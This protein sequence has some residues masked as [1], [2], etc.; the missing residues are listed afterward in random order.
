MSD[1]WEATHPKHPTGPAAPSDPQDPDADPY[2]VAR[3]ICLRLL[4]AR[5]RTRSELAAALAKRA[6]PDEVAAQ[7]LGRFVELGFI[8]DE[9]FAR[10]WVASRQSGKGLAGRALAHELRSKGVG[11]DVAAAALATID[12]A[13]ELAKARELVRRRLTTMSGLP[14]DAQYRR[15]AGMLA[16]KGY[17]G[18]VT[19]TVVREAL[20]L[21]RSDEGHLL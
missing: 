1:S 17:S 6:V 2:A 15:L 21:D 7:V 5:A 16:R 9:A 4:T 20:A 12:P 13:D 19:A 10:A 3:A 11:G 18:S 8:D 14:R